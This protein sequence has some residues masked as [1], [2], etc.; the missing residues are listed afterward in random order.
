MTESKS[1]EC[2]YFP[3]LNS[4]A[5]GMALG[6]TWGLGMLLLGLCHEWFTLGR[7]LIKALGSIYIG[8]KGTYS[9]AFIGLFW[10]LIDGFIGGFIIGFLYNKFVCYCPVC[11]CLGEKK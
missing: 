9:G 11:K 2:S 3:K 1:K 8:F 5:L 6:L 4:F 7:P 10:G